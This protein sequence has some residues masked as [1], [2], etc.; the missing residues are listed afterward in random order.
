M[1]LTFHPLTIAARD[2]VAEDAVCLTLGIPPAV[3]AEYDFQPGQH[4][5][6]RTT[7]AGKEVR[8]TYSIVNCTAGAELKIGVRIQPP[9]G[10]SHFLAREAQIGDRIEALTP[11]GRFCHAAMPQL[12]R[13]YLAFASGSGITPVLSIV[14]A[15]LE[16]EPQARLTLVYGNRTI[17]RTM[18]LEDVLALKNRFL[19]R[20][21]VH[22]VMSREPHE[23]SLFN[24][25]IDAA[26]VRE[27]ASSL[28]D[29]TQVDEVFVCGPGD[30][31]AAT[32]DALR[33]LGTTAPIHFERFAAGIAA[34]ATVA[35]A[36]ASSERA[37]R[38]ATMVTVI[39]DGRRRSFQMLANDASVLDAAER[40]GLDLPFSCRA[41]VCSTCRAKV[42][43]GSVTMAHNVALE[44]WELDAGFVLCCQSRPTSRELELSYDEK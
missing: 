41:G 17:A 23:V 2:A 30:M 12:A 22:F 1:H 15:V 14:S 24:G 38:Q 28:F 9:G 34:M 27:L 43:S 42:L 8:R 26:K 21:S 13:S 40:A 44:E 32:R 25:R 36:P 35:A 33:E 7:I 16:H 18:F 6:L 4:V 19:G 39:Q 20:L 11:T 10:L 5:A 29:P 3:R 37:D 31:V